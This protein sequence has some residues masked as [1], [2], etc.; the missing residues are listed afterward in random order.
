MGK[1]ITLYSDEFPS[2]VWEE[3]CEVLKIA[4]DST[5]ARVVFNEV[6]TDEYYDDVIH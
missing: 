3:Y 4:P 5:V 1:Y 2:D 6:I